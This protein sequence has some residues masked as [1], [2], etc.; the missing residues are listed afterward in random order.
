MAIES[1]SALLWDPLPDPLPVP[2]GRW[3]RLR[4]LRA[5]VGTVLATANLSADEVVD[6]RVRRGAVQRLVREA[7]QTTLA[8]Q[9]EHRRGPDAF[10]Q[11]WKEH[12]TALLDQDSVDLPG[13]GEIT[14]ADTELAWSLF[15][16]ASHARQRIIANARATPS[17]PVPRSQAAAAFEFTITGGHHGELG[18][19][20]YGV[21][22]TCRTGLLYKISFPPDWQFNGLGRLALRELETRHPELTWFTTGQYAWAKGFYARLRADSTS[23]WTAENNP[24]P[25]FR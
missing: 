12:L 13:W 18:S 15:E 22:P 4:N 24:C 25:H 17:R 3:L 21:C 23:P 19:V 10:T 11:V 8:E 20:Q 6:R 1:V 7:Y 14:G 2:A 16:A 9:D 5:Q